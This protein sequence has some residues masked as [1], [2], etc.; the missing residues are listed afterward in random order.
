MPTIINGTT[1]IDLIQDGAVKQADLASNVVGN[2]PCFRAE[3]A[4]ATVFAANG[5]NL[6]LTNVIHNIGGHYSAT[7]G[8]FQPTVAGFYFTDAYMNLESGS[9]TR[10]LLTINISSGVGGFR[11]ADSV[12]SVVF[13]GGSGLVYLNG[14]TDFLSFNAFLTGTNLMLQTSTRIS[15]F[16][17]RSA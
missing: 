17:V 8:R 6:V 11:A 14:T 2:G 4:A 15:A 10:A 3:L 12:G 5:V 13:L 16:L 7:T 9:F 1:G